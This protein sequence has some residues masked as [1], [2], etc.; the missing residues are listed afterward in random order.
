MVMKLRV[1]FAL[2][3]KLSAKALFR[4]LLSLLK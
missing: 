2:D 4:A 3:F 1:R